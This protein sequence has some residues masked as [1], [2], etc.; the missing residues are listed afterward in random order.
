MFSDLRTCFAAG[1][2][3]RVVVHR[4]SPRVTVLVRDPA[5]FEEAWIDV[6]DNTLDKWFPDGGRIYLEEPRTKA[7]DSRSGR[8]VPFPDDLVE[9]VAG[10][11][12]VQ[13]HG[14][15]TV[16]LGGTSA[17]A[18]DFTPTR[19]DPVARRTGLCGGGGFALSEMECLP[20]SADP[21]AEGFVTFM[22]QLGQPHRLIDLRSPEG[23]LI[24][25]ITHI[26][27]FGDLAL[28]E[29]VLTTLRF[30]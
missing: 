11:P 16:R 21:S 14:I 22:L 28:S 5:V 24:L 1:T 3:S 4:R 23:R 26:E 27:R 8:I 9:F 10:S 13:V 25:V 2:G 6:T 18:L 19:G 15:R 7:W 17:R 29:R 20:V 30:G 12:Y